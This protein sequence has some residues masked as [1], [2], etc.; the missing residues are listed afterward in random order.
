M[1]VEPLFLGFFGP[2]FF[3]VLNAGLG[4][5]DALVVGKRGPFISFQDCIA[6]LC[7]T[8]FFYSIWAPRPEYR[9]F[10]ANLLHPYL[11]HHLIKQL[12]QP[13]TGQPAVL[14]Q[15]CTILGVMCLFFNTK[16]P[17]YWFQ[18]QYGAARDCLVAQLTL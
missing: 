10:C 14:N 7:S 17:L 3:V 15:Y 6:W 5:R 12:V 1:G 8:L 18:V 13:F 2:L 16:F 11:Q 4:V 9:G